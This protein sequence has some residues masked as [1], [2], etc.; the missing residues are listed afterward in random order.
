MLSKRQWV[1]ASASCSAE[2]CCLEEETD[3]ARKTFPS[4]WEVNTSHGSASNGCA[5]LL[6]LQIQILK[7][8]T[9][10]EDRKNLKTETK[11]IIYCFTLLLMLF[12]HSILSLCDPW[13]AV[14]QASLPVLHHLPELLKLISTESVMPS[15]HLVLCHPRLLLPSIFLSIRVFS[16]KLALRIRWPKYGSFSFSISPSNEYLGLISFRMDWFDILAVQG[17]SGV[18]KSS[19]FSSSTI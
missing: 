1:L 19:V 5:C 15:N 11:H 10:F 18:L 16:N 2:A 3:P 13:T 9:T 4:N 8:I 6:A 7:V 17:T 12:S 14:D